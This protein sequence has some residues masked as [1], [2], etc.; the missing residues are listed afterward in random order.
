M[1]IVDEDAEEARRNDAPAV[2]ICDCNPNS[3]MDIGYITRRNTY[4]S[5]LGT[6][7]IRELRR[8]LKLEDDALED[9]PQR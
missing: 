5:A 1:R 6:R 3:V 8:Y 2:S 9:G 4:L 7:Y